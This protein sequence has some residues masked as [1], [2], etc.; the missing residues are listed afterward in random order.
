MEYECCI[1]LHEKLKSKL[2]GRVFCRVIDNILNIVIENGGTKFE[3][4][5]DD[6]A[7]KVCFG[8]TTDA[9]SREVEKKYRR[10]LLNRM[11]R[12]YFRQEE[13]AQF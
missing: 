3:I 4:R 8:M 9:V 10:F 6:F 5:I 12:Y 2:R 13:E 7:R 11:E 1:R